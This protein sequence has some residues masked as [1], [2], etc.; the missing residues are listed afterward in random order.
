MTINARVK[1]LTLVFVLCS[2]TCSSAQN[3]KEKV[4]ETIL[5]LDGQFW[6]AYN[7]CDTDKM[8]TFF[9]Q[10]IEFYHDKGG[11][12]IGLDNFTAALK[13]GLCGNP[14]SHLRREAVEGTV[15]V[16]PLQKGDVI[17]G[18]VISGQHYFYVNEKGNPEYRDG[19]AKF[20]HVWLL[21][22]GSWKMARVISYDH[23]PA[24]YEN[25]HKETSLTP[26]VL[27]QYVGKYEAPKAG[28]IQ[29]TRDQNT[30][31]LTIGDK[32]YVL[33]PESE[34]VFFTKDRDVTFEFVKNDKKE[35]SKIV[36]REHGAVVE[37]AKAVK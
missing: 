20:F 28:T 7:R 5:R 18:A 19:L 23:G 31:N 37:E 24:P 15:K 6:D 3:N 1:T 29:V 33:Y 34:A 17:Y 11:V 13:N 35:I 2:I 26:H 25:K 4:T 27:D 30:L 22:D 12:T 8:S 16:F 36:V 10:D 21:K 14:N 32:K 9:T